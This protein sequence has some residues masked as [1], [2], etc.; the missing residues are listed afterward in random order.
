[1]CIL[2]T[3]PVDLGTHKKQGDNAL[4]GVRLSVSPLTAYP[5]D[6]LGA[7]LCRVEQRAIRAIT[8]L[9]CVSVCLQSVGELY[10]DNCMDP[11]DWL[12]I[13]YGLIP[14]RRA[15]TDAQTDG[16]TLPSTLSPSFTANNQWCM[17]N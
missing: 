11:V 3:L 1:M 2:S 13:L 5:F 16:R 17:R 9:R 14:Y 4:G 15:R 10:A 12:L 7:W 6:L 8:S